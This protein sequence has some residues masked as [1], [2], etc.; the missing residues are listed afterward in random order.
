MCCFPPE[1]R[2]R[3][4]EASPRVAHAK[5]CQRSSDGSRRCDPITCRQPRFLEKVFSETGGFASP[6]H[7]GFALDQ[8]GSGLFLNTMRRPPPIHLHRGC[9]VARIFPRCKCLADATHAFGD[10]REVRRTA[11]KI[12]LTCAASG[13]RKPV[14]ALTESA[15]AR[16][17]ELHGALSERIGAAARGDDFPGSKLAAACR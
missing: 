16:H 6:P 2:C 4:G 3:E 5:A 13:A 1:D 15:F 10:T 14:I 8:F 12:C 17:E 9:S 11:Q 7:D